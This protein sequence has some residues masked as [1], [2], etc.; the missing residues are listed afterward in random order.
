MKKIVL[1]IAIGLAQNIYA[2]K[3]TAGRSR[4]SHPATA[5]AKKVD[6]KD[7]KTEKTI[8]CPCSTYRQC[9]LKLVEAENINE[10]MIALSNS[11]NKAYIDAFG[12]F[13]YDGKGKYSA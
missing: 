13:E 12:R 2:A 6:A 9:L 4:P 11:E 7:S 1:I 3:P 5:D 8:L 10:L